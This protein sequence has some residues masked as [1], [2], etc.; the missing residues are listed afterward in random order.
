MGAAKASAAR[1]RRAPLELYAGRDPVPRKSARTRPRMTTDSPADRLPE[2]RVLL[3]TCPP[4]DAEGLAKMLVEESLAACVNVVPAITSVYRWKGVLEQE[5]ESLL[6]IKCPAGNVERLVR[7][8]TERH[9]YDVPEV[10]ELPVTGGQ[11]GYIRWVA[12]VA[13]DSG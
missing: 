9:P 10:L 3:S 2:I 13:R 12:D 7:V 5:H 11:E 6:V 8:L 4:S 1:G